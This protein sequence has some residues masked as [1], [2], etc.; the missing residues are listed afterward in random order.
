MVRSFVLKVGAAGFQEASRRL[1][2]N[3][4]VLK[5]FRWMTTDK[6]DQ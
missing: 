6:F 1:T 4:Y 3:I 5:Q 2:K